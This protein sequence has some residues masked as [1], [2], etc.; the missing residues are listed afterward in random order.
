MRVVANLAAAL[1]GR[2]SPARGPAMFGGPEDRER[3]A[4]L[5]AQA[6]VVL[7]GGRSFCDWPLPPRA[8][9]RWWAEA[10]ARPPPPLFVVT[11]AARL[12]P[13]PTAAGF[14]QPDAALEVFGGAELDPGHVEALGGRAHRCADPVGAA[15]AAA[16]AQGA[17]L[18]VV[19]G[20]WG[21]VSALL[22]SD[23]V[24]E[25]RLTLCPLLLGGPPGEG[26]TTGVTRLRLDAAEWTAGGLFLRYTRP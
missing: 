9:H 19:E 25:L 4:R 26:S 24:D 21:L 11:R 22:A 8:W 15:L 7:T 12:H 13:R 5:R 10:P 17:A 23:F 2:L 3:M 18:L 20:G 14:P 6:D 1:D 16:R